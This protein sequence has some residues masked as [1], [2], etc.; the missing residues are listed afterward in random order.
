MISSSVV[1]CLVANCFDQSQ[2][3]GI[4]KMQLYDVCHNKSN[5]V[6]HVCLFDDRKKVFV[7]NRTEE[8]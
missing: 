4:F 7:S 2:V 6:P 8:I 5:G 3:K 1:L